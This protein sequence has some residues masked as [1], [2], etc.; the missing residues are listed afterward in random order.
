ME[1]KRHVVLLF[2]CLLVLGDL[3][4]LTLKIGS[5]APLGTPWDRSLRELAEEWSRISAG[6]VELK[7]FPGGIA[8]NEPDMIRKV[9]IGQ[10]QGAVLSNIG[11]I[12]LN[13]EF[14]ILEL[15]MTVRT[16]EEL[17]YLLNEMDDIYRSLMEEK[18][19]VLIIWQPVGWVHF[20]T[21]SRVEY[22]ED[23][24]KLKMSAPL[25]EP[26]MGQVLRAIGFRT[27]PTEAN[28]VLTG[29]QTRMV[30]ACYTSPI[31]AAAS[32]WFAVANYMHNMTF[33]PLIGALV[34]S[35]R[36]WQRIP[37]DLQEELIEVAKKM[38]ESLVD[39]IHVLEEMALKVML[40][41]G[42]IITEVSSDAEAAWVSVMHEAIDKAAGD[43]F[44]RE[45][46]EE[47]TGLLEEYRKENR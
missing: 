19:F 3:P 37:E 12:Y 16:N 4:A 40:E 11:L 42:L 45:L 26:K 25:N 8:G 2:L 30:E 34:I 38:T 43:F 44:S 18:G 31:M 13:P 23:M 6:R 33:A 5:G 36:T 41:N 29:L 24:M 1:M 20:F 9:R 39:E 28:F 27:F 35:T 22:P 15:P 46:Y 14:L 10:L 21:T 17:T 47:M 7:I 32:Q